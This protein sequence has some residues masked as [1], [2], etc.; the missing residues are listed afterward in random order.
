MKSLLRKARVPNHLNFQAQQM[1]EW[2]R[3]G[4]LAATESAGRGCN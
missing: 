2:S 4:K 1:M 3:N